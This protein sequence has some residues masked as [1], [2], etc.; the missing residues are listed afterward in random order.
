MSLNLT[1]REYWQKAH[2]DIAWPRLVDSY[3]DRETYRVFLPLMRQKD[4]GSILELGCGDSYWLP[5][6]RN[7]YSMEIAG[8]DYVSSRV[9]AA[10][11]NIAA[12]TFFS[13]KVQPD[14]RC[15]DIKDLQTDWLGRFDVV[16]SRGVM[17]HFSDPVPNLKTCS[18]YLA[19]DGLFVTTVP[20]LKGMWGRLDKA[21]ARFK[22]WPYQR[23]DLTD[24]KQIHEKAGL[25]VVSASY[26][27]L[28]DPSILNFSRTPR[29]FQWT[30]SHLFS[31]IGKIRKWEPKC[32]SA[33]YTDMIVVAK[34]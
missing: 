32:P 24:L 16:Y 28:L 19:K 29:R 4:G 34:R 10:R 21:L 27:R 5:F 3:A 26:F 22:E 13:R 11:R 12:V 25:T 23:W 15:A 1:T 7:T 6:W 17:E 18:Q 2:A 9:E 20:H 8:L 31:F 14:L 30:M 33:L